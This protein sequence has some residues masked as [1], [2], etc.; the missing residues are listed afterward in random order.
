MAATA[1]TFSRL[2]SVRRDGEEWASILEPPSPKSQVAFQPNPNPTNTRQQVL[3]I[4][5]H[6]L[7]FASSH[8]IIIICAGGGGGGGGLDARVAEIKGSAG[9]TRSFQIEFGNTLSCSNEGISAS[10]VKS[11]SKSAQISKTWRQE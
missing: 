7:Y 11:Y 9:W 1:E 4:Q 10:S 3:S 8:I 2:A 6:M 5:I